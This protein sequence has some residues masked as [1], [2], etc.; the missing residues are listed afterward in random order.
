MKRKPLKLTLT[1]F[2]RYWTC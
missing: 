1:L 2:T